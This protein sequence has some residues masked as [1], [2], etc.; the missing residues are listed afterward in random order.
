MINLF[1]FLDQ[2]RW[3]SLSMIMWLWIVTFA[4]R[5]DTV[6]SITLD[7]LHYWDVFLNHAGSQLKFIGQSQSTFDHKKTLV[8]RV[9]QLHLLPIILWT[10]YCMSILVEGAY[11]EMNKVHSQCCKCTVNAESSQP[12]LKV[13]SQR[14]CL[15]MCAVDHFYG[16]VT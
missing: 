15:R 8:V 7:T 3:R 16:A 4:I 10:V 2:L 13:H 14:W 5:L 1:L 9:I 12:M 11:I 6:L